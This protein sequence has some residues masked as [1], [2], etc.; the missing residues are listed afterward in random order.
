[1][2]SVVPVKG[3]IKPR[4]KFFSDAVSELKKVAWPTRKEATHLTTIVIIVSVAMGLMLAAVDKI[5]FW[6]I[7]LLF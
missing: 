2:R 1:M 7:N 6:L 3:R 5:F 4:F